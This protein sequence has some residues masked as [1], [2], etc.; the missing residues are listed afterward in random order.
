MLPI[1]PELIEITSRYVCV[2]VFVVTNISECCWP[3][4]TQYGVWHARSEGDMI[5]IRR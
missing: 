1:V 5:I 4:Q 2:Q 3:S